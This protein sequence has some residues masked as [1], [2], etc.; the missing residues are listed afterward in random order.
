MR[1]NTEPLSAINK[2][3]HLFLVGGVDASG[4]TTIAQMLV[5]DL[6]A[7]YYRPHL[8]LIDAAKEMG[9]QKDHVFDD[10][11]I[12][13]RLSW[14]RYL[15][16]IQSSSIAI[17]DVHFARQ[18]N[19]DTARALGRY[20][21]DEL[22]SPEPY[23]SGLEGSFIQFLLDHNVDISLILIN[24]EIEVTRKRRQGRGKK[25]SRS[26]ERQSIQLEKQSEE[27]FFN[28]LVRSYN[29]RHTVVDN[30]QHISQTVDAIKTFISRCIDK[31][32]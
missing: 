3:T 28:R 4:K 14:T 5:D 31:K 8:S 13:E 7:T 19:G 15:E 1:F 22:R 18:P 30:N 16:R 17:S 27:L 6:G 32:S 20:F 9:I 25:H 23:I 29:L 10:N 11:P 21:E 12:L 26:L 2:K 24:V